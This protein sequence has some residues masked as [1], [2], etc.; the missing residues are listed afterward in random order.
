MHNF[1][2]YKGAKSYNLILIFNT[3]E[4]KIIFVDQNYKNR[5]IPKKRG[6]T[7]IPGEMKNE[8]VL[9]NDIHTNKTT[10]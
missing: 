1:L 7:I 9:H 4:D 6:R 10:I 3:N 5:Y 2:C 8:I